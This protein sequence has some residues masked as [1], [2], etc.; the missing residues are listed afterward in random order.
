MRGEEG[1]YSRNDGNKGRQAK[2]DVC[3]SDGRGTKGEE[4]EDTPTEEEEFPTSLIR[5]QTIL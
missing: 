5:D 4:G 3:P 1:G 2:R